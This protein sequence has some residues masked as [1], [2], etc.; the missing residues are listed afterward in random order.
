MK[1]FLSLLVIFALVF[2]LVACGGGAKPKTDPV[3]NGGN[4]TVEEREKES[5]VSAEPE[6][7]ILYAGIDLSK[8]DTGEGPVTL[9]HDLGSFFVPEGITYEVS[10]LPEDNRGLFEVFYGYGEA[11]GSRI[12]I[13]TTVPV[14]S[15]E[16]AIDECIRMNG[17]ENET[18][19]EEIVVNGVNY[20][21]M[22]ESEEDGDPEYYFLVG[23]VKLDDG[24]DLY[25]EFMN[26]ASA[27][28]EGTIHFDDPNFTKIIEELKFR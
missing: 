2:T 27:Y 1:R 13:F 19:G 14:Y 24:E 6:G 9:G 3:V 22:M 21:Y 10:N 8:D 17:I 26:S 5:E 23:H 28:A 25:I 15:L 11:F 7:D 16:D 18:I 4:E 12:G 20:I